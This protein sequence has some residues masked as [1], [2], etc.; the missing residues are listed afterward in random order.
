VRQRLK[1]TGAQTQLLC[2]PLDKADVPVS[3]GDHLTAYTTGKATAGVVAQLPQGQPD[4]GSSGNRWLWISR[5]ACS[6]PAP[7]SSQ[8]LVRRVPVVGTL[9]L[10]AEFPKREVHVSPRLF[11]QSRRDLLEQ[12]DA[13]AS[14]HA[15]SVRLA[16]DAPPRQLWLRPSGTWSSASREGVGTNLG[17]EPRGSRGTERP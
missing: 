8:E 4:A 11:R 10:Q 14:I 16:A 9:R 5:S 17:V 7:N 13:G 12:R 3:V 6:V 2:Q 15:P 1:D